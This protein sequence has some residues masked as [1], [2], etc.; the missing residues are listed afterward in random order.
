M[1]LANCLRLLFPSAVENPTPLELIRTCKDAN[2]FDGGGLSPSALF[3]L[4]QHAGGKMTGV[5]VEISPKG[6]AE[7]LAPGSL[8]YVNS[9]EL[10]NAQGRNKFKTRKNEKDSHVVLVEEILRNGTIVVI[11]PDQALNES[12]S[13]FLESHWGRMNIP[14]DSLEKVWQS[15][16]FDQ[17]TTTRCAISLV[18]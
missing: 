12:G 7:N 8:M 11:N 3:A 6:R 16:R 1:S 5:T 9:L 13:G 14:F 2:L 10:L 15:K 17:T 4:C 18:I